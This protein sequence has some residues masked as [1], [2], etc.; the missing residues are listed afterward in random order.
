MWTI[1]WWSHWIIHDECDKQLHTFN[2]QTFYVITCCEWNSSAAM[3]PM[4]VMWRFRMWFISNYEIQTIAK[5]KKNKKISTS[6]DN[7]IDW[8]TQQASIN[9]S[10]SNLN[11]FDNNNKQIISLKT[12]TFVWFVYG[13]FLFCAAEG[14]NESRAYG[15]W[16]IGFDLIILTWKLKWNMTCR[17]DIAD[18]GEHWV[19]LICQCDLFVYCGAARGSFITFGQFLS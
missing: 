16:W 5:Q 10:K 2:Q 12:L 8:W 7:H 18:R 13:Y 4:A 3:W 9:D 6:L 1:L 19:S 14:F 15:N 17:L 11:R